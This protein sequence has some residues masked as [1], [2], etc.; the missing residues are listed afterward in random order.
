[1]KTQ[2][3]I[4]GT[5]SAL[6]AVIFGIAA[7][8]TSSRPAQ[9]DDAPRWV[10]VFAVL[11]GI[12]E[13]VV[14]GS[15]RVRTRVRPRGSRAFAVLTGGFGVAMILVVVLGWRQHGQRA[16]L[17]FYDEYGSVILSC[18]AG[19]AAGLALLLLSPRWA[20]FRPGRAGAVVAAVTAVV[21]A[22]TVAPLTVLY[23]NPW[24]TDLIR[25]VPRSTQTADSP[26]R[27]GS[28]SVNVS[29]LTFPGGF[30]IA[31]NGVLTAYDS[32]R[33]EP[34]WRFDYSELAGGGVAELRSA[35]TAGGAIDLVLDSVVIT[36][37]AS[38]GEVLGTE[39]TSEDL[40]S[41]EPYD[42]PGS[43]GR[44]TFGYESGAVDDEVSIRDASGSLLDQFGIPREATGEGHPFVVK[45]I[46][47]T[48]IGYSSYRANALFVRNIRTR[49]TTEIS[50]AGS[51][52]AQSDQLANLPIV[53]PVGARIWVVG[54]RE[55]IRVDPVSGEVDRAPTT[56][57]RGGKVMGVWSVGDGALAWCWGRDG[58]D[59]LATEFVGIP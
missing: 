18:A 23:A 14:V 37:A 30:A 19:I 58:R 8:I 24:H 13:L 40:R 9:I 47:D 59:E 32:R 11:V 42:V 38:D 16:L 25:A 56:C 55:S 51:D 27:I 48:V 21:W 10:A 39:L 7:I 36:L 33:G 31:E 35:G 17:R 3:V 12:G 52:A 41:G 29:V 43:D 26:Y 45:G 22:S 34:A 54:G 2:R 46:G 50:L 28:V 53:A 49:S 15:A 5:V 6:F 1:M 44:L 4:V 20:A 57:R